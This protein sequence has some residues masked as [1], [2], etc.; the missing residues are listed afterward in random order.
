MTPRAIMR[1][2]LLLFVSISIIFFV[3]D[4]C[5]PPADF[6]ADHNAYKPAN[7]DA[8]SS[9]DFAPISSNTKMMIY[10]FHVHRRCPS[11][12]NMEAAAQKAI[13]DGFPSAMKDGELVW[14]TI[15]IED[16]ANRHFTSEYQISWNSLVL[17]KFDSGHQVG[18]R[19]LEQIWQLQL[20]QPALRDYIQTQ[21]RAYL[22]SG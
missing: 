20:D 12:R 10:Y 18:Y 2:T 19:Y 21:V 6:Y 22:R 7:A 1:V 9:G 14:R 3:R 5:S 13:S 15:D 16:A 17:V 4:E 11:C 8:L